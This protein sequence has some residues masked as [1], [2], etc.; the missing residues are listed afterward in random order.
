MFDI[1]RR[2]TALEFAL[3]Y[4]PGQDDNHSHSVLLEMLDELR[5]NSRAV[6]RL[7]ISNILTPPYSLA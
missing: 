7:D 3:D 1:S 4:T 5:A 2:I 6:I